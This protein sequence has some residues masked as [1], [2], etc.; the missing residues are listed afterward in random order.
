MGF[1]DGDADVRLKRYRS[2]LELQKAGLEG[3]L[4][5]LREKRAA[6]EETT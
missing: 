6:A 4:S 1:A 5:A 3:K 2:S